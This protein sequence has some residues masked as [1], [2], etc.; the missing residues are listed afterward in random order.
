MTTR[1]NRTF[2]T[3][4]EAHGLYK[5]QLSK[6]RLFVE[7]DAPP[8]PETEV[9][10]ELSIDET[11]GRIALDAAVLKHVDAATAQA[12]DLGERAGVILNVPITADNK[13]DLKAL[14]TGALRAAP[15]RRDSKAEAIGAEVAE[16]VAGIAERS[17]YAVLGVPVDVASSDLR[18]AYLRLIRKYH[19]DSYY[20]RVSETVL[21]DLEIAYQAITTAFETLADGRRRDKYDI[22][23]GNYADTADGSTADAK[24][25][26]AELDAYKSQNAANI[27]RARDLFEAACEDE[28]RGDL[29]SARDK[30]RL[31]STFDPRN[32]AFRRKLN[33]LQAR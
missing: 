19:P 33:D 1:L 20:K 4:A 9:T 3:L 26:I 17:H 14:L 29:K 13:A 8:A 25:K 28:A 16:F 10:L 15:A 11:G 18:A 27:K 6:Q 7:V 30:L 12:H 32:P 22:E 23:I 24:R 5:A 31:A 2:G 21:G